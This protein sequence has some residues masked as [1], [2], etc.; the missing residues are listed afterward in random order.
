MSLDQDTYIITVKGDPNQEG[1]PNRIDF[2]LYCYY[3]LGDISEG[4][5]LP[6]IIRFSFTGTAPTTQTTLS[7]DELKELINHKPLFMEPKSKLSHLFSEG[8]SMELNYLS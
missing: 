2:F 8:E 4:I 7:A 6:F 1:F 5:G 3:E